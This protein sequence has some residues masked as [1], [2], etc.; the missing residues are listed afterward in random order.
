MKYS[1]INK[2]SKVEPCVVIAV[3]EQQQL[4]MDDVLS[5]PQIS[6]IKEIINSGEISGKEGSCLLLHAIPENNIERILIIG[7]GKNDKEYQYSGI[8]KALINGLKNSKVQSASIAIETNC[9]FIETVTIELEY[10]LYQYEKTLSNKKDDIHLKNIK[11]LSPEIQQAQACLEQSLAIASGVNYARELANLPANYCTP[12]KL[13]KKAKNLRSPKI[14]VEVLSENAIKE[15]KMGSFMSVSAGSK[16]PAK[17]IVIEYQGHATQ[18][19]YALVGKGVTFDSGG[20]SLK[21]GSTMDEMKFDMCGAASV[22]GV[23]KAL[24]K[25][26]LPINVV[27]V[28]PATENMPGNN[29]TKPSDVVKSMS[30]QT[31]EILNTD[32]EGRLILCDALTYVSKFKPQQVIDIATLTGACIVALGNNV[33]GLMSNNDNL[34]DEL[35][36]AGVKV[37][38]KVW[39]MPLADF[40][41]DY[42]KQLESNFADIANIGERGAGTITAA[43]FL[44]KFTQDYQWAHI[45]IA[46]TA[47]K[48]GKD[49]GATGRPVRLLLEYLLNKAKVNNANSNN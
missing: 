47:W 1:A 3:T 26:A 11:F 36:K 40:D 5:K 2:L 27:G 15:L 22:I 37:N 23:F 34:A 12:T 30:G 6:Y 28:I 25:M 18:K 33:S 48:S 19:P 20:I 16:E 49:K 44:A 46:G 42:D 8:A 43:C 14:K 9:E 24:S 32:A 39:R 45:D 21:P 17:L 29:A 38:D 4:I 31:I 10:Q 13:S 35:F 7:L 41:D